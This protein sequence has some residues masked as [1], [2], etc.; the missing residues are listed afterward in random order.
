MANYFILQTND[1]VS[2]YAFKVMLEG[3]A[4][5]DVRIQREQYTTTGVL[6]VQVGPSQKVLNY[7]VKIDTVSAGNF[8]VS[9]GTIV[10]AVAIAWGT[11]ANL[12]TLFEES[13]PPDNKLRMCDLD[14]TERWVYFSGRMDERLITPAVIGASSYRRVRITLKASE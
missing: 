4:P 2:A 6:D 7:E 3:F 1:E 8:N 10:T 5:H 11:W 9:A 14:G 13:T 12:Q